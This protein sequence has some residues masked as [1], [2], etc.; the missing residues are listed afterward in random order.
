MLLFIASVTVQVIAVLV[1]LYY[2][3]PLGWIV[4]LLRYA[5]YAALPRYAK[6][7]SKLVIYVLAQLSFVM[8]THFQEVSFTM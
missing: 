8:R 6:R 2:V 4:A 5:I 3:V 1:A 7:S